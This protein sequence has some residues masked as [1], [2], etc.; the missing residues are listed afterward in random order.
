MGAKYLSFVKIFPSKKGY[1]PSVGK[2]LGYA[3][4]L[5]PQFQ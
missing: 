2:I 5:S 4:I 1:A 3:A